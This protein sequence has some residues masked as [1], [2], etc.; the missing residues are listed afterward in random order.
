MTQFEH[1]MIAGV[2]HIILWMFVYQHHFYDEEEHQWWMKF[3]SKF[4]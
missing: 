2:I 3:W 4:F 1:N